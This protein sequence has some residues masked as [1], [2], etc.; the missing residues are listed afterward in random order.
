MG[1]YLKCP[2]PTGKAEWLLTK[3]QAQLVSVQ[4]TPLFQA[5]T[6]EAVL[7]CVVENGPFDAAL[8]VNTNAEHQRVLRSKACGDNRITTWLTITEKVMQEL[9]A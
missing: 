8:V 7:I 6:K 9:T 3:K 5:P 4:D 1:L 2:H